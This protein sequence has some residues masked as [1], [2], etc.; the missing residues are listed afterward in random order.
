MTDIRSINAL[1]A[2]RKNDNTLLSPLEC[3]EDAMADIRAGT[4]SP[5]SL[6]VIS[7]NRGEDGAAYNVNY[8]MSNLRSSEAL[9]LADVFKAFML[10]QMGY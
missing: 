4:I 5:T 1:R 9:A 3:L 2:D 10:T 7:L 8:N 6:V